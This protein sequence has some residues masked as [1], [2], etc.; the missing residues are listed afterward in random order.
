[1]ISRYTVRNDIWLFY[2]ISINYLFTILKPA[3]THVC[4]KFRELVQITKSIF[5]FTLYIMWI[6][7]F[8]DPVTCSIWPWMHQ[9][10]IQ[11]SRTSLVNLWINSPAI[12][13]LPRYSWSY[14]ISPHTWA[15][16][17]SIWL[18]SV[19]EFASVSRIAHPL[20]KITHHPHHAK[21][22]ATKRKWSAGNWNA[23]ARRQDLSDVGYVCGW[24]DITKRDVSGWWGNTGEGTQNMWCLSLYL[25]AGRAEIDERWHGSLF[26]IYVTSYENDMSFCDE[27][28]V[29][30]QKRDFSVMTRGSVF[31]NKL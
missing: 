28:E 7:Q 6:I 22:Y 18:F 23:L 20:L 26:Q 24:G 30:R 13:L 10:N 1:M 12:L 27:E 4:R 2:F 17:W 25:E 9:W 19:F 31:L 14:Q 11:N 29:M 16:I 5:Q 15:Y 3:Y 8:G 21:P